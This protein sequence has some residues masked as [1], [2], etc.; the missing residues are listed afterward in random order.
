[1]FELCIL[2]NV[3]WCKEQMMLSRWKLC[4]RSKLEQVKEDR[5]SSPWGAPRSCIIDPSNLII[6]THI[7]WRRYLLQKTKKSS[8]N[9][10]VGGVSE[11]D[12]SSQQTA[13]H[14]VC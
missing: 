5:Q 8:P 11:I 6:K 4:C 14:I 10:T 12:L 13:Y 1:M 7:I 3:V 2:Y 9:A